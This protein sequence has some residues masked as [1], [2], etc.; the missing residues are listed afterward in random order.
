MGL[1]MILVVAKKEV[2]EIL[3]TVEGTKIVG[4]VKAE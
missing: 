4:E 3:E 2:I 1:G